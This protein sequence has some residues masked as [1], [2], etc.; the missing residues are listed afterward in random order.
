MRGSFVSSTHVVLGSVLAT[1]GRGLTTLTGT[2]GIGNADPARHEK[3]VLVVLQDADTLDILWV[4]W[5]HEEVEQTDLA[6]RA[7]AAAREIARTLPSRPA[8]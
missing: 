1:G 7:E 2:D 4:G 8:G 3:T 6:E 5:S